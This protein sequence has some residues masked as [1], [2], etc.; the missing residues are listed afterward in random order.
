[1]LTSVGSCGSLEQAGQRSR[2]YFMDLCLSLM[3]QLVGR[4]KADEFDIYPHWLQYMKKSR[5]TQI[6]VKNNF[7]N[8][9][10]GLENWFG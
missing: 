8:Q 10:L 1:M 3:R 7:K 2:F 9:I 6:N 5:D 4:S